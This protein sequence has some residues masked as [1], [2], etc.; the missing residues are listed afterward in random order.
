MAAD[1]LALAHQDKLAKQTRRAK[2]SEKRKISVFKWR[3]LLA[4]E[5]RRVRLM[6][7]VAIAIVTISLVFTQW[8]LVGLGLP[9]SYLAYGIALLA[10]VALSALLFGMPLGTLGGFI[11][12]TALYV[13]SV[14]QPLDY[15]EVNFVTPMSSI[16]LFTITGLLISL[17]FAKAL[18]GDRPVWR[19]R[20]YVVIV[21]LLVSGLFSLFFTLNVIAQLLGYFVEVSMQPGVTLSDE[22][23]LSYSIETVAQLGNMTLQVCFDALLMVVTCLAASVAV[24]RA[25]KTRDSRSL[26]TTFRVWLLVVVGLAF[27]VTAAISFV[28]I[29]TDAKN[30]AEADMKEEIDYLIDQLKAADNRQQGLAAYEKQVV[31]AGGSITAEDRDR[32]SKIASID[33]LLD[34]YTKEANGII[35]IFKGNDVVLSDDPA[36]FA[37]ATIDGLFDSEDA[38]DELAASGRM[39]Q[40]VF[41]EK[42]ADYR[43]LAENLSSV[44]ETA[45]QE[46]LH[47]PI[48]T[49]IAYI[50]MEKYN[51]YHA[52]MIRPATMVFANRTSI[53]MWTTLSTFILLLV[54]SLVASRL[55]HQVVVRRIDETNGVLAD[56]TAGNLDAR[57][58]IRDSREF[59][60][61]SAGIN[62]TV[63]ALKNWIAEAETRMDQELA[64]AKAIQES[65]LPGIFP[66]FP[67]VLRFDIY[68]SMKA[69]REVGG[70]FYDFFLVGDDSDAR[71]GKLGFVIA[72]VSGKG[73]PA[74]LFMMA[75]KTQVRNYLL[76]GMSPGEAVENANRQL[77]DGNN[78]G[79]FVTLFAGVLDYGT[80]HVDYVN[81]GH[82]PPLL[83]QDGDWRWLRDVSG[84]PLGLF[85]GLPYDTFETDLQIGDQLLLYTDGVTEAMDVS[86]ALYGEDRLMRFASENHYLHPRNL[87]QKLRAEL[88]CYARGAE[89]SDDITMLALEFGVPPEHTA[90]F[91]VVADVENLPNV[92]EFVHAEL[93]RRLCPVRTQKQLDIAIEELFVNVARYAYPGATPSNPGR[94]RISYTYSADPPSIVVE[95]ADTG[96]PYNPL[97]KPDA[98]TPDDIM[99]VPIGGLGILMAKNSVDNMEY[100]RLDGSNIVTITKKW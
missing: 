73:V 53:M 51:D 74:A 85:D 5:E 97:E 78:A 31:D 93:D 66:P 27:S 43:N 63:G 13:H 16:V 17:L 72:D 44:D 28:L 12:G 61:L 69:A 83:W 40:V 86:G 1:D 42:S 30:Q 52:M 6:I 49:Q 99:E 91:S 81:A 57:V 62:S 15:Y 94:A 21:C 77:C 7:L 24:A 70:D 84:L 29:T 68:A 64:T 4:G 67:D 25:K 35:A 98:V 45:Q 100:E 10:P 2:G 3:G 89:Q 11:A 38:V 39:L 14:V 41:D 54:V 75:A 79:M 37:D 88:A 55:L 56:I 87:V 9:G 90:T 71:E 58:D 32:L 82:N 22:D 59:Q 80:G 34:G 36:Y 26:R 47:E 8:G 18:R 92:L 33:T 76:S 60:S 46:L 48:S 96:I 50:Y 95:I 20:I 23:I 65:A 19:R